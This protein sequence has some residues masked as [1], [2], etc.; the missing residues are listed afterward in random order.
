[1]RALNGQLPD[2][3]VALCRQRLQQ[4]VTD[5]LRVEFLVLQP[6]DL[7]Q[8]LEV[9]ASLNLGE[10]LR[11]DRS[12]DD[13]GATTYSLAT[14]D[15]DFGEQAG[16]PAGASQAAAQVP[17]VLVLR[18]FPRSFIQVREE[19]ARLMQPAQML[20]AAFAQQATVQRRLLQEQGEPH[21]D[22]DAPPFGVLNATVAALPRCGNGICEFGEAV[23]T[24][25]YP[26]IWHCPQDCPFHLH[27]CPSQVR[28]HSLA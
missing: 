2:N 1:M 25:G 8:T 13:T 11:M 4:L 9:A 17:A 20:D 27:A 6:A 15:A 26:D 10:A 24:W 14:A 16:E 12:R 7:D 3:S 5:A 19:L 28:A 23:G 18:N 22:A 21:S